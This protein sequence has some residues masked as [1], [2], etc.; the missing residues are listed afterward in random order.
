MKEKFGVSLKEFQK[1]G[2][3][4]ILAGKIIFVS[5]PTGSDKT[6]FSAGDAARESSDGCGVEE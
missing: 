4:N 6:L 2:N 5:A 3:V 1:E